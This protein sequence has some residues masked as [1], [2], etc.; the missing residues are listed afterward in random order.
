MIGLLAARTLSSDGVI[1]TIVP[2][3]RNTEAYR[4]IERDPGASIKL[5]VCHP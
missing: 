4:Q 3:E 1:D 5:A 2:F